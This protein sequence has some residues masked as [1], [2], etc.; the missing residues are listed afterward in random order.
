MMM[1]SNSPRFP[2]ACQTF[3]RYGMAAGFLSAAM[4]ISAMGQ[5]TRLQSQVLASGGGHSTGGAYTL[6]GTVGQPAVGLSST[7]MTTVEAGFWHG[8]ISIIV[9]P[10]GGF[11]DWMASF[12]PDQ[13]PPPHLR[14]PEDI[15]SGDGMTNLLKYALDLP[16]MT[17]AV[18]SA[19]SGVFHN[20][21]WGIRLDRSVNAAVVLQI[22]A[23]ED[24]SHWEE[25]PHTENLLDPDI[26]PNLE[27]VML[28]TSIEA[29]DH[30]RYF[31]RLRVIME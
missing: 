11:F 16:P 22:E 9:E 21:F 6:Q 17:P 23:S 13:Q 3:L 20:G 18:G 30:A 7:A 28:L 12:P 2:S 10:D 15:A 8:G 5:E 19:P 26:A 14:G 1:Q 25:V 29:V 27:R 4:A 31:F 24:L